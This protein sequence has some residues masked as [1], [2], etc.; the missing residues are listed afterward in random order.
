[1]IGREG[2]GGTY[3]VADFWSFHGLPLVRP[4]E[5]CASSRGAEVDASGVVV[6]VDMV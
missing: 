3:F 5:D 2:E 4:A 1:V 6:A